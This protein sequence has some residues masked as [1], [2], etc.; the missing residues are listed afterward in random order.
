MSFLLSFL[1]SSLMGF[2]F[3]FSPDDAALPLSTPIQFPHLAIAQPAIP[4]ALPGFDKVFAGKSPALGVNDGQLSP[5]PASPNCVASQ[6]DVDA[7]H[8]IA[9]IGYEGDRATAR[10]ALVK[11]I[12]TLPRTAIVAD[13]NDYIRIAATSRLMGFVDDAE[14]YFPEDEAVI[15]V[16]SASRLGESDL[17][18]NRDRIETLRAAVQA[19]TLT[20]ADD[21]S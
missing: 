3:W 4:A 16:R 15:Q 10:D 6:G 21:E 9:P 5:C 1:L 18:V 11:A 19:A 13:T 12:A 17:G 7:G 20:V 8:K 2:T 14:F